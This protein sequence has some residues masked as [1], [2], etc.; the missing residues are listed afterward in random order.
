MF[1]TIFN[2]KSVALIGA[3]ASEY[4]W[5]NRLAK[6]LL[7]HTEKR[8]VFFVNP[9][10]HCVE[11]LACYKSIKDL[12]EPVDMAVINVPVGVFE[13][14]VDDLIKLGVKVIVGITGGFGE[15]GGVGAKIQKRIVQKC[16]KNKILLIGPN[17]QGIWD[18]K[19]EFHCLPLAEFKDGEVTIVSQSGGVAVNLATKLQERSIGINKIITLGNNADLNLFDLIEGL[20]ED[21]STKCIAVYMEDEPAFPF[22]KLIML[23]KHVAVYCPKP[24]PTAVR[25]AQ[26]H[27]NSQLKGVFNTAQSI[28]QWTDAIQS[29]LVKQRSFGQRVLI[30]TDSGGMGTVLASA[31]EPY[32]SLLL[33]PNKELAR[34]I[35]NI[36]GISSKTLI[37]NPLDLRNITQVFSDQLVE[38]V[39]ILTKCED[40]DTIVMNLQLFGEEDRDVDAA[41]KISNLINQSGKPFIFCTPN[42]NSPA[43]R[44]LLEEKCLVFKEPESV[45]TGLVILSVKL[46]KV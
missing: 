9:N 42:F 18:S 16:K 1:D 2:P 12:P 15:N 39:D 37:D 14:A 22:N 30:V 41:R 5:G 24:T 21:E 26:L 6:Q 44:V 33:E 19:N 25:A 20:S 11:G 3:S 35:K 43:I 4:K 29:T 36:P 8:S 17:S 27:S 45:V 7:R 31:I 38:L 34:K 32:G 23:R 13:S 10:T 46:Q 40:Y 28:N